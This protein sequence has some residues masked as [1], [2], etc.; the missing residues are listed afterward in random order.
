MSR[1]CGLATIATVTVPLPVPPPAP[2]HVQP[3]SAKAA[4]SGSASLQR[5]AATSQN[6]L[7]PMR[8]PL[9]PACAASSGAVAFCS[10]ERPAARSIQNVAPDDAFCQAFVLS[11][12]QQTAHMS[13]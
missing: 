2:A 7:R 5:V 8:P 1:I 3:P 12:E 9:H 10:F 13:D 4:T 11:V 6:L